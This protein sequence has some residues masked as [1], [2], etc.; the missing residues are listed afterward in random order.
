MLTGDHPLR[1]NGHSVLG[2]ALITQ[3]ESSD[4]HGI[5]GLLVGMGGF[6]LLGIPMVFFIWRFVNEIL[7]GRFVLL[8][9][10]LAAVFLIVFSGLLKVLAGRVRL[11]DSRLSG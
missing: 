1:K 4:G 3:R 9:A 10:L 5:G 6:V 2:E 8:D 11:W 7:T